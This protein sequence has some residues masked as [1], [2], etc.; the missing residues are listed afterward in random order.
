MQ[1]SFHY[2]A[3]PAYP[4]GRRHGALGG[5]WLNKILLVLAAAIFCAIPAAAE[6]EEEAS[7]RLDTLIPYFIETENLSFEDA[8]IHATGEVTAEWLAQER[9]LREVGQFIVAAAIQSAAEWGVPANEVSAGIASAVS[10]AA[11]EHAAG[12]GGLAAAVVQAFAEGLLYGAVAA[13]A[14]LDQV[15]VDVAVLVDVAEEVASG[16]MYGATIM[17]EALGEDVEAVRQSLAAGASA[18]AK[19]AALAAGVEPGAVVQSVANGVAGGGRPPGGPPPGLGRRGPPGPPGPP[20]PPGPPEHR[21]PITRPGPP[22]G[23]PP[24][25][26]CP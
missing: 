17:A 14:G 22:E 10:Q 12:N 25:R 9:P 6:W 23:R 2:P 26:P 16:T 24:V 13:A 1:Y 21:P 20:W 3:Y 19:I 15:V 7:N 11:I 4:Y 18:G 5:M 8:L